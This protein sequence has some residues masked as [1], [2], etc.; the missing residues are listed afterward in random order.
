MFFDNL[1]NIL[2]SVFLRYF[3]LTA[4]NITIKMNKMNDAKTRYVFENIENR[5]YLWKNIYLQYLITTVNY[6]INHC[7]RVYIQQI[8]I[9]QLYNSYWI[10]EYDQSIPNRKTVAWHGNLN[11]FFERKFQFSFNFYINNYK[12]I[13]VNK[14]ISRSSENRQNISN[15]QIRAH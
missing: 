8:K 13:T 3:L 7:S 12:S 10:C 2:K 9:E 4:V 11:I 1:K 6:L 15:I 5:C 14:Y